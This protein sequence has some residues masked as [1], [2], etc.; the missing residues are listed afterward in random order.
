MKQW[1]S[2]FSILL[3]SF[4]SKCLF[5]VVPSHDPRFKNPENEEAYIEFYDMEMEVIN[6]NSDAKPENFSMWSRA[7]KI[8]VR[9][10][11]RMKLKTKD[12]V[13]E[14]ANV[15][16][17]KGDKMNIEYFEVIAIKPDGRKIE[18]DST[19]I[20]NTFLP[21]LLDTASKMQSIKYVIPGVEP[22]DEIE[23][24]Y[25]YA[26][27]GNVASRLYGDMF[28]PRKMPIIEGQLKILVPYPYNVFYKCYNGFKDPTIDI[29][30]TKAICT[31]T[32][33]SLF[34]IK[35]EENVCMY[36]EPYFYF[37]IEFQKKTEDFIQWI[38]LFNE[39]ESSL[40]IPADFSDPYDLAFN[41]WFKKNRKPLEDLDKFKQFAALYELY[42]KK[43]EDGE[44]HHDFIDLLG[45]DHTGERIRSIRNCRPLA[46][47][48]KKLDIDYYVCFM[49]DKT[50]GAID[51]D[52]IR[53]DEISDVMLAYYDS[54]SSF[55]RV[56]PGNDIQYCH[57][58]EVPGHFAGTYSIMVKKKITY[59]NK[60]SR[61]NAV[62]ADSTA[63]LIIRKIFVNP[64]NERLNFQYRQRKITVDL[65]SERSPYQSALN[66]SG[67]MST[68]NR[69]LNKII[70]K[71]TD[72]FRD[73]LEMVEN[74]TDIFK[75]DSVRLK[76]ESVTFPFKT[77]VVMFGSVGKFYNRVNDSTVLVSTTDILNNHRIEFDRQTRNMDIVTPY[78]Y[79]DVQEL[80]V[81]FDKP[82]K[83]VNVDA[84]SKK[85]ENSTGKYEFT[86][87]IMGDNDLKLTSTYVIKKDTITLENLDELQALNTGAEEMT[88]SKVIV[89][90]GREK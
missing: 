15:S 44:E 32:C 51:Q 29:T 85:V 74:D 50:R 54:D 8:I 62:H 2:I 23:I 33:D 78:P 69:F 41:K 61:K 80:I 56:F 24:K 13:R 89:N 48:L 36:S 77:T 64:G 35:E 38:D 22:G 19:Q 84:L 70:F 10:H 7:E 57:L 40:T 46:L 68:D 26:I 87:L 81:H 16:F 71:S 47:M 88:G 67:Q 86:A 63:E 42:N 76:T 14:F 5:A 31:F 18:F 9:N 79:T 34:A 66:M 45:A 75:V 30:D 27:K 49:R 37:S 73:Y 60:K 90:L 58:N 82:V 72:N 1:L 6:Q 43:L 25:N 11:I 20:Y 39:F 3:F 55:V 28:L 21:D 52:F 12:A 59:P 53:R 17:D 65:N 4:F 83:F